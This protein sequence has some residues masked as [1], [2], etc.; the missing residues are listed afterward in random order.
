M[1]KFMREKKKE[2]KQKQ[3][4]YKQYLYLNCGYFEINVN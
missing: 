1:L 3:W 4:I 2:N